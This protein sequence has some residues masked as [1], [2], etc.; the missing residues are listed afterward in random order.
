MAQDAANI[1]GCAFSVLTSSSYSLLWEALKRI[2][3]GPSLIIFDNGNLSISS[4]S[5]SFCLAS[6]KFS[7][8]SEI[9]PTRCVPCPGKKIALTLVG[10]SGAVV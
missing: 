5:S 9:M 2:T 6:G 7:R 4:A 1:A 8:K 3:G 10:G